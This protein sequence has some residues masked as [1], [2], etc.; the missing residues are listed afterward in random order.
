LKIISLCRR[1]DETAREVY[2]KFSEQ[3]Q[4]EPLQKFW[5]HMSKEESE[6]VKFW[7][8]AEQLEILPDNIFADPGKVIGELEQSV[9]KTNELLERCKGSYNMA[10]SFVLSYRMEFYLL[11]PAFSMLFK[12][13]GPMADV[14]NPET[15]YDSHI[16]D[17][18]NI[19]AKYGQ[20]TPEL[21][22]LGETLQRLWKENKALAHQATRD[23]LTGLFNR[24]G[25][26][27]TA[28][29]L[30]Y[31]AQRSMST[32][33]VLMIDLDHFKTINDRL[34]HWGADHVLKEAARIILNSLR[35]SDLMGRY[36]GEEFIVLLP[37]TGTAMTAAVAEKIRSSLQSATIKGIS[38]TLSIGF[39]EG[40]IGDS[41]QEDLQT[42]I[43]QADTALY[44]AKASGRNRVVEYRKQ[45]A[46]EP[47][48]SGTE[49]TNV[50]EFSNI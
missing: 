28:T 25:F 33:G 6:H 17:F 2:M 32:V 5:L 3:C 50:T 49:E 42:L 7:L 21:E 13:L 1:M 12:L 48:Q 20:V 14:R 47:R 44:E 46:D 15:N 19:L 16:A 9:K 41:P 35:S 10:D 31:L 24:R 8:K 26:F 45:G 40:E 37:A 11:H 27:T 34:G 39:S 22:L 36:G 43:E 38:L 29:Q 30:M 23:E 4:I 18:I